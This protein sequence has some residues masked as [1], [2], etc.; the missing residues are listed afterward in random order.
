[1]SDTRILIVDDHRD[2]VED[3]REILEEL[4]EPGLQAQ[5]AADGRAALRLA[6][7]H[8]IDVA[9]VDQHLPDAR[10]TDLIQEIRAK[11][12]FAEVLILTG[13]ATVE[14]AIN[15]VKTSAFAYV[16]KPFRVE[17]LLETVRRALA[18]SR[19]C[20]DRDRLRRELE[21]SERRHR[22]VVE[23]MPGFVLALDG[24]G[25]IA[26]WNRRL[27]EVTGVR[28]ADMLGLPGAHLVGESGE[29]R[30]LPLSQGGHR[31][32]RWELAPVSKHGETVTYALGIDVTDEQEMLR[33]TL[34]AERLAAVGTLAAGL[35]HEVR[36]P[37][38]S[39]L[40]QLNVLE[41][42]IAKGAEAASLAAVSALIK[43]EI[44]RLDRLVSDF[45]AFA[46]PRPLDLVVTS[47]NALVEGVLELVTPE[48]VSGGVQLVRELC[49]EPGQVSVEIER[50]R[51]VLLNL[52]RN[53]LEAMGGLG[54][55]TLT[56][57]GP[58]ERGC[59]AITVSDT[60][61]GFVED[62]PIFDAFYTTKPGGTG[63]G[64]AIVHRIVS[65]HGGSILVK[66]RPGCT[67]FTVLL[68]AQTSS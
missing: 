9:I 15:A 28:R 36:N 8:D 43:D 24:G 46:Q 61:P 39:A 19:L 48:V 59:C 26:L 2:L 3:L 68:P 5:V 49:Q 21:E 50:L 22:E 14:S 4:G 7:Q 23:A 25:R 53:A 64:L 10:G 65:E 42:R 18:Q 17:E 37:M 56:T 40:L 58:D 32:V 1:M 44:S 47:V 54:T 13:D 38:N 34:R 30:R 29:V 45:L 35:A 51:Q 55:L 60:G 62:A 57:A 11:A 67:A 41:R 66:S 16:L 6:E 33:R 20:R 31:L 27:E 12:P 52:I 63:L